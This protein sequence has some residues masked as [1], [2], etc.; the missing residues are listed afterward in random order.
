[1]ETLQLLPIKAEKTDEI[2]YITSTSKPFIE[3]N[4]IQSSLD[5]VRNKHIIPVYAKDNE[6]LISIAEFIDACTEMVY[7]NFKSETIL[8]PSIR[9]SH[10]VKGR[11]PEAKDKNA[12]ELQEWEKTL[13]YE[14]AA[15]VIEIPSVQR[16]ID[17]NT[18]SLTIGGVKGYHLDRLHSKKGADENFSF[19]IGFQ[20]KVCCNMCIWTDGYSRNVGVK[21]LGQL[22]MMMN[23]LFIN[24]NASNQLYHLQKL[25]EFEITEQQFAILIGRCRMYQNIPSTMKNNIP[26]ML[27]GDAQL[28]AVVKD[29]YRDASFCRQD[30]GNINLWKLYNLFTGSNKSSYIDTFLE[31]S[32]NAYRFVEQIRWALEG[33][34]HSWF[35]N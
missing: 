27:Y 21:S 8:A 23:D 1:M 33:K 15:F 2:D 20:N 26:P 31:R 28:N 34:I 4:T 16:I 29:Y 24:Y 30:N 3:S 9:L 14:R 17:G 12:N 5:E 25:T 35:L 7:D 13:Y 6:R 32:V 11:V 22:K 19:F 10:P 18:L